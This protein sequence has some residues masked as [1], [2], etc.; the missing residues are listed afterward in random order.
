MSQASVP[1]RLWTG[2]E[3]WLRSAAVLPD[4]PPNSDG[5]GIQLIANKTPISSN[6]FFTLITFPLEESSRQTRGLPGRKRVIASS[7]RVAADVTSGSRCFVVAAHTFLF[8]KLPAAC[9]AR[10]G[11]LLRIGTWS[12]WRKLWSFVAD[13]PDLA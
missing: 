12:R 5:G 9:C 2:N 13:G 10:G 6:L 11:S 7:G 8:V 3:R 4:A 1:A